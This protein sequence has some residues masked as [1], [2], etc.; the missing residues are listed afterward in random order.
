MTTL[1]KAGAH[2]YNKLK[3]LDL[4]LCLCPDYGAA[5]RRG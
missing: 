3:R 1:V 2:G 4:A 5:D